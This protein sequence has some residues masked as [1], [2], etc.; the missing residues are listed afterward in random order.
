MLN[1]NIS[2]P[3]YVQNNG[4]GLPV[5]PINTLPVGAF[6]PAGYIPSVA[7]VQPTQGAA[8]VQSPVQAQAPVDSQL[9]NQLVTSANASLPEK[10]TLRDSINL[11]NTG[12]PTIDYWGNLIPNAVH[13][14]PEIW[15]GVV[16]AMQHPMKYVVNPIGDWMVNKAPYMGYGERAQDIINALGA[17]AAGIDARKVTKTYE[18]MFKGNWD[19][20]NKLAGEMRSEFAENFGK[21]PLIV[22]SILAPKVVTKASDAALKGTG[23]LIE[24]VS[25]GKI[26]VGEKGRFVAKMQD[27]VDGATRKDLEN[28]YDTGKGFLDE[29]KKAK[30][31]AENNIAEIAK[32]FEEGTP[33]REE[34][35]PAAEKFRNFRD[36]QVKLLPAEGLE[37][38]Q[39]LAINQYRARTKNTTY[40]QAAKEFAPFEEMLYDGVETIKP[41][42]IENNLN[43]LRSARGKEIKDFN[44]PI[45]ELSEAELGVLN[46]YLKDYE[47]FGLKEAGMTVEDAAKYL[48]DKL[49]DTRLKRGKKFTPEQ[50]A[51]YDENYQKIAELAAG[52]DALAGDFIEA[53][54]KYKSGA[55]EPVPH[56]GI[57]DVPQLGV[58]TAEDLAGRR[59]AGKGSSREYGTA[60]YEQIGEAYSKY[61]DNVFEAVTR[62]KF[63]RHVSDTL[64]RGQ[65][66]DGTPLVTETTKNIRYLNGELLQE[67]RLQSAL[68]SSS[69]KPFP[70]S[71]AI[72]ETLLNALDFQFGRNARNPFTGGLG[73]GYNLFKDAVLMSGQYL[74]GNALSG[75]A[76]TLVNSN[77]HI[78]DDMLAAAKSRGNLAKQ[79]GVYRNPSRDTKRFSTKKGQT[80][81]S[82]NWNFG[83][84]QIN[85]IDALMQNKFA[86]IA[87]H[88]TLRKK[89]IP[90]AQR[91]AYLE[92]VQKGKLADIIN[93]VR[94]T[95]LL[96]PSKQLIPAG[97]QSVAGLDPFFNWK[98]TALQSSWHSL[99]NHPL[100]SGI[101][102]SNFFGRIAFDKEMQERLRLGVTSDKQLVTYRFDD[103]T[104]QIKEVSLD[105]FPQVAALKLMQEPS[106]IARTVPLVGD[107][108]NASQGKNSFGQ[109]M[110]RKDDK[111]GYGTIIQGNQRY[112]RNP[113]TGEIEPLN[114]QLDEFIAT[115]IKDTSGIPNLINKTAGPAAAGLMNLIT[116]S[117]QYK[118]YQP[119]GQGIFG[120]FDP[121][122]ANPTTGRSGLD[123]LKT[124]SGTYEVPYYQQ[125]P[126]L[127]NK[128]YLKLYE[129]TKRRENEAYR[130]KIGY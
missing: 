10:K 126:Y 108:I 82:L 65:L 39:T 90:Y 124:F 72:D 24:N 57:S 15:S 89:G 26:P 120:S 18:N 68:K 58:L 29:V 48:A 60:T 97:L 34:L 95:S 85:K 21:N 40:N 94:N 25:K 77:I 11:I 123:I 106:S 70:N 31:K 96:T 103:R 64:L 119:Y 1:N 55:L 114:G 107:L 38:S 75:L 53:L 81:H 54:A 8:P 45:S 12:N 67:G 59:F 19:E 110:K 66:S 80:I 43:G 87:A 118:Y 33:L 84:K 113:Q 62:A 47:I 86:E 14:V 7:P 28:L 100:I 2:I 73:D 42:D 98:L 127:L 121:N 52:G 5:Q 79:L 3:N 76:N 102:M 16:G 129:K 74:G 125:N 9:L 112:R 109:P 32:S 17:K 92:N 46:K 117:N 71:V 116:G 27:L 130:N 122:Q 115:I 20:A 4:Q 41:V 50:Q 83:G 51:R 104:G 111:Y 22:T 37:S 56:F 36:A 44:K 99:M 69:K 101:V 105:F 128:N 88:A 91:S 30:G 93:D 13:D 49:G 23:N 61:F 78:F 63:D 35:I 6:N